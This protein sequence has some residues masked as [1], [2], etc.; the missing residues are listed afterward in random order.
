M[1]L[2]QRID[3]ERKYGFT[4]YDAQ[5]GDGSYINDIIHQECKTYLK[6]IKGLKTPFYRGMYTNGITVGRKQVRKDRNPYG[7]A[8]NEAEV[9]NKMLGA[10]GHARRDKSVM[11]TSDLDHIEM[12][13]NPFYIFPTDRM[14]YTWVETSDMNMDGA[15]GWQQETL[16][17]WA[18]IQITGP[19][20][21][22]TEVLDEL[23]KPFEQWFHTNTG[24]REAYNNEYEIW[25]ESKDYIF[26]KVGL[27]RWNK[28]KQIL[29]L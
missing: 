2:K 29:W 26:A 18:D 24:I 16:T 28:A 8:K 12:F 20:H 27:W 21:H 11:A 17:S 19:H 7:M 23:Y 1:R 10:N 9:L 25:F 4:D 6:L 5:S 14:K 3:E 13:G 15:N 22:H